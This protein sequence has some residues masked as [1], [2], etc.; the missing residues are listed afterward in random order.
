MQQIWCKLTVFSA[1][2]YSWFKPLCNNTYCTWD[3]YACPRYICPRQVNP[4]QPT[5]PITCQHLC[6]FLQGKTCCICNF[7]H[8]EVTP[9]LKCTR[10]NPTMSC[11]VKIWLTWPAGQEALREYLTTKKAPQWSIY[12]MKAKIT[13]PPLF[14]KQ[15]RQADLEYR[16]ATER[17]KGC[18]SFTAWKKMGGQP[19]LWKR[20]RELSV[21]PS[22]KQWPLASTF[23]LYSGKHSDLC[24]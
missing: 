9:L 4:S 24:R 10:S 11:I 20:K 1:L 7:S 18:R 14:K 17:Q 21:E 12:D 22:G 23:T 6:I 8:P 13:I 19:W 3:V 15:S 5:L 2:I 16:G